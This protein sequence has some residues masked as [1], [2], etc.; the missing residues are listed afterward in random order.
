MNLVIPTIENLILACPMCSSGGGG[1][2]ALTAAN[3]A[4]GFLLVV[5]IAVL[6]SFLSFVFY[7]AKRAKMLAE[8]D[9]SESGK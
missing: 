5:I 9:A 4:I 3:S 2:M 8:E 6:C 1:G 7:L